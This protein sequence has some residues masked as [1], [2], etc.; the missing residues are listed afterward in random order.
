MVYSPVRS[1]LSIISLNDYSVGFSLKSLDDHLSKTGS[2]TTRDVKNTVKS[3]LKIHNCRLSD[4][5]KSHLNFVLTMET[6]D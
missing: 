1:D 4:E 2:K 3:I 5:L 6:I